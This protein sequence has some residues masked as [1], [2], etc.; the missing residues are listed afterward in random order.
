M[1]LFVHTVPLFCC[2]LSKEM[3]SIAHKLSRHGAPVVARC[4][5]EGGGQREDAV[6]VSESRPH[7]V[8]Y[9]DDWWRTIFSVRSTLILC[10]LI[11]KW[12]EAL[13]HGAIWRQSA[14]AM[15]ICWL[16]NG[17]A[18]LA[19]VGCP[20]SFFLFF[21]PGINTICNIDNKLKMK[22]SIN[23]AICYLI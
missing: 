12:G 18:Q 20:F 19:V 2:C 16:I 15:F 6:G 8:N 22:K 7:V 13:L 10:W 23:E 1:I 11:R 3:F 14:E 4:S 17:W 9:V 21:F 5:T